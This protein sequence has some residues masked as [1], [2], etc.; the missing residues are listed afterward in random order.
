M[1]SAEMADRIQELVVT[2]EELVSVKE[3]YCSHEM[4]S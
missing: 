4:R 1:R 3:V 2:H